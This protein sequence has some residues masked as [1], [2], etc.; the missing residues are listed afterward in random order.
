MS[1]ENYFFKSCHF[2]CFEIQ[3]GSFNFAVWFCDLRHLGNQNPRSIYQPENSFKN[4]KKNTSLKNKK[5][6]FGNYVYGKNS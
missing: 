4:T 6:T 2:S 1:K 5:D 3:F